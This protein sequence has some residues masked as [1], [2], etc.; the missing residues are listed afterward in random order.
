MTHI[1][2]IV[3]DLSR[4]GAETLIDR[5]GLGLEGYGHRGKVH[6]Q[7]GGNTLGNENFDTHLK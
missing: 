4:I 7:A 2:G 6:R 1:A 5:I 3:F